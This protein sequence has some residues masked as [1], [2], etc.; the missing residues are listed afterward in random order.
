MAE[1]S[2]RQV[3]TIKR[4]C[5]PTGAIS[6]TRTMRQNIAARILAARREILSKWG[7]SQFEEERVQR[8]AIEG[9]DGQDRATLIQSFLTPLL[10]LL[11][12]Y[13]KTG[14]DRYAD[15][16]FDE[17]MRYA[18]HLAPPPIRAR[19]FEEVLPADEAA[20]L[21]SARLPRALVSG[22]RLLLDELHAPLLSVPPQSALRL[23]TVGD[24]L[25]GEV[26]A[27]LT[28]LCR[29]AGIELD[30]RALYFSALM[31]R[32][33]STDS[34]LGFLEEFPADL[35]AFSFLSY[36][37]IPIYRPLLREADRLAPAQMEE[38][39]SA[40]MA[41]IREFL[42]RLR[43]FTDAPFL[44]HNTGGLP[45]TTRLRRYLRVIPPHS[46][47]SRQVLC[48]LNGAISEL[49]AN[50]PN[51]I[52]IDEETVT[53]TKGHHACAAPMVP[54]EIFRNAHF[55][56]SMFGKYLTMEYIDIIRCYK[57]L[58]RAKVLLLDFD[59]T[60]WDGVMADGPVRQRHRL[61]SLLRRVREAGILLVAVSKNDPAN[62]R[63]EEMTLKPSD[64]VLHKI[65]WELKVQSIS[66]SARELDLGLESFVFIDDNPVE[67][68]LVHRQFP[69]ISSLDPA[70]PI[71]ARWLERMLQF[72]NTRATEEART[73][74]EMYRNQSLRRE[75]L[76]QPFDYPSMM[77][78]LGLTVRFRRAADPDLDR[79]VELVQRTNQFNTTTIRYSQQAL[80]G[81][82]KSNHHAVYVAALSDK[83]GSS[84]L[85]C[86]SIIER[87][88]NDRIFSSFVMSCRAMGFQLERLVLRLVIDAES[89]DAA[90]FVG[91][92][93][94]TSRNT[95]C[96]DFFS[97]NGFSPRD[98]HDWILEPD[99]ARPEKPTWFKII[100]D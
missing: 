1:V 87:D 13:V 50:T 20:I 31:E 100:T 10:E 71:C 57:S 12:R 46:K 3:T 49:V 92:F 43:D 78:G 16:Y 9:L 68:E 38:R 51:A 18:P 17:R 62:V 39:V 81:L 35:I 55:H 82:L 2:D 66:D 86:V 7:D 77:A 40:I 90:R 61:Q 85:V 22:L 8:Y 96:K 98:D 84:G 30:M 28:G 15:L 64:F 29:R 27:A 76:R 25:M 56:T 83:F 32:G 5:L 94:P 97:T 73:R 48:A 70:D 54:R 33:L 34:V 14:E 65:G 23:L 99:A 72:P 37:G 42:G 11:I 6:V 79:V 36:Q 44:I 45:L 88:R 21:E 47:R 19:F 95:P 24:C 80:E 4:D 69:M 75:A 89:A 93:L 41:L 53:R 91:R 60:L 67:R 59:D 74:T 26:R 63:W 58:S 52:L